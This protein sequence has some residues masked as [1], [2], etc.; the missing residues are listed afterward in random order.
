MKTEISNETGTANN[1]KA[2]VSGSIVWRWDKD[3]W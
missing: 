3:V 2:D 1:D